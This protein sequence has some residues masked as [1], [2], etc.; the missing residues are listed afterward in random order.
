MFVARSLCNDGGLPQFEFIENSKN[1]PVKRWTPTRVLCYGK[2]DFRVTPTRIFSKYNIL[3]RV[4]S[5]TIDVA[6]GTRSRTARARTAVVEKSRIPEQP[7]RDDDS[8]FEGWKLSGLDY[9]SFR[10]TLVAKLINRLSAQQLSRDSELSFAEWRVLCRLALT[11]DTTVRDI[12]EHAWVDRAEVS[13]AA[14]RLE[15]A[16]LVTR[17]SNPADERMPIFSATK[18]GKRL[19]KSLIAAR[20]RFHSLIGADLDDEERRVLDKALGKMMAKLL[21]MARKAQT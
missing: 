20:S 13:R 9:P 17:R 14:A 8:S 4:L 5:M 7:I 1:C 11:E 6:R 19:Y 21:W 3:S 10:L 15:Q 16:G 2:P 12:A 18:T